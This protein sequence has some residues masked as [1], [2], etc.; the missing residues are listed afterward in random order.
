MLNSSANNTRTTTHTNAI[1]IGLSSLGRPVGWKGL[2]GRL[3]DT[4]IIFILFLDPPLLLGQRI[5]LK[6]QLK[7]IM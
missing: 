6:N 5:F 1:Y 2:E 3:A 7:T 4:R